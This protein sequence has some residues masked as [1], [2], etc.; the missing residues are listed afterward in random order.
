MVISEN[1]TKEIIIAQFKFD[2]RSMILFLPTLGLYDSL[3]DKRSG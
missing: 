2:T 1:N 3:H